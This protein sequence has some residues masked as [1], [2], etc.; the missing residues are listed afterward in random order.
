MDGIKHDTTAIFANAGRSI[1]D[2]SI[3]VEGTT[4]RPSAD[5]TTYTCV[6]DPNAR[7][8]SDLCRRKRSRTSATVIR[9]AG[10]LSGLAIQC[11]VLAVRYTPT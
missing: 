11:K 6:C 10:G 5:G 1:C 9:C 7:L 3:C 4:C 8:P 2:E